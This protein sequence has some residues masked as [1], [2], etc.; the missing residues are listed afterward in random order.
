MKAVQVLRHGP[1]AE[2]V[3]VSDIAAPMLSPGEV[4]VAVSAASLNFGDIARARGGVSM[5]MFQPPYTLGMDVCGVV[6]AAGEGAEPWLGR[7]VVGMTKMAFGG[8]AEQAIV[9]LTSLFEAPAALDDAEATAF[10][11]PFHVSYLGLHIRARLQPGEF[12]LVTAAASSVGTAAVQ[13]AAA[14]GATVIAVAG[15]AEKGLYCQT[16]GASAAIDHQSED[17]F[18][19]VMALTGGHGV[20]VAFDLVGGDLTEKIWTCM[21]LE[22]RYL[23]VGFNGD[24]QGGFTG[25][26]LR[27]VS[28]ANFSV[29]GV[30]LAYGPSYAPLRR[31]GLNFYPPEIGRQ[32]HA[33]LCELLTAG[34]IRPEIGRRIR[35]DEVAAALEDHEARR[36]T[37]RT[38]L[39]IA[40]S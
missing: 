9:P 7:R 17:L 39:D 32:V 37:G 36:T 21:A 11:L 6:E 18:D 26:P 25:R 35:M 20:D 24:S 33:A 34:K 3:A 13:L 30:M 28:M 29:L 12:V 27:K 23:P 40:H 14:A 4:R 31:M 2:V 1:P 22:G 10:L 8:M 38:I 5:A 15:G 16:L 19:R